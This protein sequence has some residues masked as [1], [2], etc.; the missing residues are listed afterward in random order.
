VIRKELEVDSKMQDQLKNGDYK[1]YIR[2]PWEK[3]ANI[4]SMAERVIEDLISKGLEYTKIKKE[5]ENWIPK[6]SHANFQ[7]EMDY[8]ENDEDW[9]DYKEFMKKL[10]DIR[11]RSKK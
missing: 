9:R 4:S 11:I 8:F 5:I 2:L 3:K 10:L 1:T 6:P 7:K